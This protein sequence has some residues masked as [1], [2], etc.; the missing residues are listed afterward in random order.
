MELNI[1]DLQKEIKLK[2][3]EQTQLSRINSSN[4]KFD[5]IWLK[6]KK[7]F[8][9]ASLIFCYQ[10][11]NTVFLKKKKKVA[12]L[13]ESDKYALV[14]QTVMYCNLRMIMSNDKQY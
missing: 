5:K 8:I 9:N 10:R 11:S 12:F 7:L 2:F 3:E 13:L 14:G 6:W 4:E 1:F